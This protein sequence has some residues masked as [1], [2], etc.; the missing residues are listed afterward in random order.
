MNYTRYFI[1]ALLS[2]S[3]CLTYNCIGMKRVLKDENE[4][5]QPPIILKFIAKDDHTPL[6]APD[7]FFHELPPEV[8]TKIA[9]QTRRNALRKTCKFFGQVASTNNRKTLVTDPN[10]QGSQEDIIKVCEQCI[11]SDDHATLQAIVKKYGI[12]GLSKTNIIGYSLPEYALLLNRSNCF[13]ALYT[14]GKIQ[15]IEDR[16]EFRRDWD[17][18][19]THEFTKKNLIRNQIVTQL[20]NSLY[21]HKT[22]PNTEIITSLI[23]Y[24]KTNYNVAGSLYHSTLFTISPLNIAAYNDDNDLIKVLLPTQTLNTPRYRGYTPLYIACMRGNQECVASLLAAGWDPN[25]KLWSE[26]GNDC[27]APDKTPLCMAAQYG[28]TQCARLILDSNKLTNKEEQCQRALVYA[29]QSGCAEL[30]KLLLTRMTNPNVSAEILKQF[31]WDQTIQGTRLSEAQPIE[32]AARYGDLEIVQQL[33]A[34]GATVTDWAVGLAEKYNHD[35][36]LRIFLEE[37]GRLY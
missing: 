6:S 7:R 34:D 31:D 18:D 12:D 4:T 23:Q 13:A 17:Q 35:E 14:T 10:F 29:T 32:I 25:L 37:Q 24:L 11:E 2:L 19:P 15:S 27:I 5:G 30:V 8:L 36:I 28:F 21:L 1:L 22:A 20:Q 33:L 16:V 26:E 3:A 9:A